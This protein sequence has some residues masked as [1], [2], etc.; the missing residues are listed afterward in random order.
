[1]PRGGKRVSPLCGG[2]RGFTLI[3]LLIAT[4]LG[5]VVIGAALTMFVGAIHSQPRDT[6]KVASIQVARTT[7]DRITRELR[8]GREVVTS[9]VLPTSSRL[10]IVT[11]VKAAT[12]GGA[13]AST[14]IPCRVTY[15]C[16]GTTCTRVVAQPSGSAP[17][18]PVQVASGLVS[19]NVFTYSPNATDPSY[20]GVS[21]AFSNSSG[22]PFTLGD[23]ITLRNPSE[24]P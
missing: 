4:S 18:P 11:Y 23:G 9:P 2:E 19:P 24:E 8:Q 16:S 10:E 22:Q 7:I 14:S 20:V 15:T 13:A 17:G 12:C 5:L 21:F 3:E 1:M 6:S